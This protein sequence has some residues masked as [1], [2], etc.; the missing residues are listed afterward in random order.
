MAR[1]NY[2]AQLD[3]AAT[4]GLLGTHDSLSYRVHE[5][6]RHLHSAGSWFGTAAVPSGETHVADRIGPGIDPFVIDAGN[7]DWGSWVQ[8]LGSSDTPA[9]TGLAYYDPH[10]ILIEDTEHN[11]ATYFIQFTR[12][13]SGAVGYAAGHYTEFVIGSDGARFK[14]ITRVQT[15]RAPAGDKLWAR[16]LCPGQN[17]S[18]IDFYMGIHEYEG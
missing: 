13:A 14:G 16:C 5:A 15:G 1:V 18:E 17:T 11:T 8:I 12:G 10:E 9:R 7:N 2:N 3:N 4:L 6:E